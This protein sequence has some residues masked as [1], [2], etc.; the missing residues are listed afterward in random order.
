[1]EI[2]VHVVPM[3]KILEKFN[4]ELVESKTDVMKSMDFLFTSC[5]QAKLTKLKGRTLKHDITN[6]KHKLAKRCALSFGV[7]IA[8]TAKAI[9]QDLIAYDVLAPKKRAYEGVKI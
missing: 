3:S 8:N 5:N 7:H 2:R 6:L 4:W 1:M 9:A